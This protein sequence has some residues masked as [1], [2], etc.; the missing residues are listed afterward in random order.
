MPI[1]FEQSRAL[2][3]GTKRLS[4][5]VHSPTP[6]PSPI[7]MYTP[8]PPELAS[9]NT[10]RHLLTNLSSHSFSPNAAGS[11]PQPWDHLTQD[12]VSHLSMVW[13]PYLHGGHHQSWAFLLSTPEL[14]GTGAV[15]ALRGWTLS[16]MNDKTDARMRRTITAKWQSAPPWLHVRDKVKQY[17]MSLSG[18][19]GLPRLRAPSSFLW[20]LFFFLHIIISSWLFSLLWSLVPICFPR[21]S[22]PLK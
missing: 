4:P 14:L 13:S 11:S 3:E 22:C 5:Y 1:K 16:W 18:R 10:G 17:Q 21:T 19:A 8:W 15:L 7:G 20:F 12:R 6:C 9:S 2:K